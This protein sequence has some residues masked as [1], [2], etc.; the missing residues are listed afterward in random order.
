MLGLSVARIRTLK[1][2]WLLFFISLISFGLSVETLWVL[3]DRQ[4][5]LARGVHENA[6]W[7]AF[8]L[9]REVGELI[10]AL[11]SAENSHQEAL[12]EDV[13]T[14]FGII[15]SRR[16]NLELANFTPAF[17]SDSNYFVLATA[18]TNK[19]IRLDQNFS[20]RIEAGDVDS[21]TIKEMIKD[22]LKLR[23]ESKVLVSET[24]TLQE[25]HRMR[26]REASLRTY[27]RLTI[28]VVGLALTLSGVIWMLARQL[29]K[30][31][32][33]QRDL[34]K[35]NLGYRKAAEEASAA[36]RTKSAFLATMSHEIRTPLN[37]I[38][39]NVEL[40][41]DAPLSNEQRVL[42]D[43]VRECGTSLLELID[44]VLDFSRLESGSLRL[45]Q[46]TFDLSSVIEAALDIVSPKARLKNLCLIGIYP[47]LQIIG[48]EA[49]LRQVLV[50]LCGNA[51]KFTEKGDVAV[52]ARCLT[53]EKRGSQLYIEVIDSGI[54]ISPEDRKGLFKEFHQVDASINRR[55]GGS[56]LG[57]AI[58]RRL[59]ETM[60]GGIGVESQVGEGSRFWFT[61]PLSADVVAIPPE[62]PWPTAQVRIGTWTPMAFRILH[63]ELGS[64]RHVISSWHPSVPDNLAPGILLVDVQSITRHQLS[65]WR[66]A[67]AIIFGFGAKCWEGHARAVIDGPLTVGRLRSALLVEPTT[68]TVKTPIPQPPVTATLRGH[69]LVVEDNMV[70]Q[71]VA[72]R[73]L[74]KMGVTVELAED[75]AVALARAAQG[76]IDL[77]LMD[78]QMPVMDGLESTRRIRQLP[79]ESGSIPI[80]G[81]TANAFASDR[82]ACL[83]AGMNDFQ[84]KPVNRQKLEI[85][86]MEW[87]SR[88]NRK[89]SLSEGGP[90]PHPGEAPAEMTTTGS[91]GESLGS[92][93]TDW[94]GDVIDRDRLELMSNELGTEM[95]DRLTSLFWVDLENLMAQLRSPAAISDLLATRRVFHTIKGSAETIGFKAISEASVRAGEREPSTFW[96]LNV[97]C[98]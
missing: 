20:K 73:L 66:L 44:D 35:M 69:V 5:E 50:N 77:I 40:L 19:I 85:I 25:K 86:L 62:I 4:Q 59:I 9:D 10:T 30:V 60:G 71:Q 84:S 67:N 76:G 39:G 27:Q 49:R 95:M 54:G 8:Q 88:S 75:G 21:S 89:S 63:R 18:V 51:V 32:A 31:E 47:Q 24:N 65:N 38:I 56:G 13:I 43:T 1:A 98:S 94:D 58:S 87:L 46:R 33:T 57:L 96:N 15:M 7:S 3:I 82:D 12:V 64:A 41:D 72:L 78:M 92:N 34:E 28:E 14:K 17:L 91:T 23:H 16:N 45:E 53:G 68:Q 29:K 52:V 42:L 81:L 79:S 80:V 74:E 55:F 26:N 61:L 83:A 11:R 6:V 93:S 90:H 70:N 37:G 48:D 2:T 22:V 36:N 97:L